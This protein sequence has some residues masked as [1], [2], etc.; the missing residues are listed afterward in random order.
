M[1]PRGSTR[2]WS[3]TFCGVCAPEERDNQNVFVKGSYFLSKSGAGSHSLVFGYDGFNDRIWK[4]NHQSGSD[5]RI[6]GT[7]SIVNGGTVTP[8]FLSG[9]TIIQWNPIF[10]DSQGT[11]FRTHSVFFSDQ[12][13]INSRLSANLGL[14]F[15]R[16]DGANSA[17]DTVANDSAWSPRLGIVWDPTGD[18]E[19][20]GDRRVSRDTWPRSTTASPTHRLP[21]A[22]RIPTSLSIADPRSTPAAR[23]S[24]PTAGGHPTG[25][26]LVLRQRRSKPSLDRQPRHP[27]SD[28]TDSRI[29]HLAERP[30]VR[31]WH[32]PAVRQSGRRSGRR[33]LPRLPRLLRLSGP[34]KRQDW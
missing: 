34:I 11:N 10:L 22:T 8:V 19:L 26:R 9:S 31:G 32:Q 14:R 24:T 18:G 17:G 13:R 21:R 5:Y 4:N 23:Q 25:L 27:R 28:T 12:W 1:S 15:D 7:T 20:V 6:L 30:R 33:G 16:N 2:Y 29:A 3:P